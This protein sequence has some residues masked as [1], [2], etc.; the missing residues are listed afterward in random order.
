MSAQKPTLPILPQGIQRLALSFSGGGFRAASFSLGCVSF[1]NELPYEKGTMLDKVK[2]ISS[3]SG[4]SITNMMLS[5]QTRLGKDFNFIFRRLIGAMNGSSLMDEVFFLLND[6]ASWVARPQK[7]RN[8]INAFAMAYDLNLFKGATFSTLSQVPAGQGYVVEESC[9]NTTEFD[10]G[11]NFRFGTNGVIGNKYLYFKGDPTSVQTAGDIRLGDILAC[12]SCFP[13]GFEPLM[14][15]QDFTHSG[16]NQMQLNAAIFESD[17]YSGDQTIASVNNQQVSFGFM[18]GGIDDNQ[19]IYAFLL[20][21]KRVGGGYDFYFTCDVTS[22]FL[23]SPFRFPAGPASP[24]LQ[25]TL[26]QL[27]KKIQRY[28]NWYIGILS[29]L[30][31]AGIAMAFWSSTHSLGLVLSGAAFMGL[32]LPL[33]TFLVL[34]GEVRKLMTKI[35]PPAAPGQPENSWLLIFNKYKNGLLKL[36]LGQLVSMLLAR[37]SSV[38]L[39]ASTV[40]LKKI[41]RMSY[42]YLY[43][44]KA[45][46]VY[47]GL[48]DQVNAETAVPPLDPG[49]LWKDHVGVTT[50]YLLSTKNDFMLQQILNNA[51]LKGQPVSSK[52][53]RL[54]TDLLY[55]VAKV[56]RPVAD[57]ATAMDTTLWF[58]ENQIKAKSME[59]IIATG[60]ATMCFNLIVM[61]Y[62][63]GNTDQEWIRLKEN[64]IEAWEKFG[65]NPF[66][67]Y[68]QYAQPNQSLTMPTLA[69]VTQKVK[70]ILAQKAAIDPSAI[71]DNKKLTEWPL[72][73]D[74][75]ALGF[76]AL[77]LADYVESYKPDKT[78]TVSEVRKEGLLVSGLITLVFNKF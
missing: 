12:S 3:A 58:D 51:S 19:G 23:Q 30:L 45:E 34:R 38:L 47:H 52:D 49:A 32:L 65:G 35:M 18:D 8:L 75:T 62:Q 64:L 14:F 15:P 13:G 76:V 69:N 61:A 73:L 44:K 41:R 7:S 4:G 72:S 11:M 37:G 66:W 20:A 70:T 56:I 29:V 43:A 2:F 77:K 33:I 9:V 22:N 67:L 40:Y 25:Q 57:V 59:S 63:F 28:K 24:I 48:V 39:L 55:A 36:S 53:S 26:P 60:Q 71:I 6:D 68:Q 46:N 31:V 1:L 21:D 50:V 42:D 16:L 17:N 27:Q 78:V 74:A 54:L 10:N 5:S